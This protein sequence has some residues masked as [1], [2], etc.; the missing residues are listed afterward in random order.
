M[1][2]WRVDLP[3]EVRS[4]FDVYLN[5]VPQR[6][7]DDYEVRSGGLEFF[8]PLVKEG[9]VGLWRWFLG[10]WG[11]GTYRKND[12]VDVRYTSGG[13]TLVAHDLPIT[14]PEGVSLTSRAGRAEGS[15][16]R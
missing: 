9:K 16:I 4:P 13:R 12:V 3:P 6:M 2:R 14:P 15:G 10:A 7:G 8:K 5:G 11:V 1:Q